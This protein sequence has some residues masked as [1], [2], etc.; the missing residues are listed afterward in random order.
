MTIRRATT[1][2]LETILTMIEQARAFMAAN[3]NP[4]Q[5]SDGYPQ[6]S[7]IEED[8]AIRRGYVCDEDDHIYAYFVVCEDDEP[9]YRHIEGAW[10][11]D[12]PYMTLH[13]VIS[14]GERHG[15]T[16]L[17]IQWMLERC[18]NLRGDTHAANTFMQRAFE[19]NGF[20]RCGTIWICGDKSMPRIAYH[21]T[22]QL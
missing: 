1:A 16:D 22:P 7:L 9:D 5:W 11:N 10:L 4:E 20:V 6:K 15:M 18:Q 13:R 14:T 17:I 2:D 3:G 19:R 8:I 21:H 12:L